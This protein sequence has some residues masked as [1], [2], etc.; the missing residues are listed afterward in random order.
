MRAAIG[1]DSDTGVVTQPYRVAGTP[2]YPSKAKQAR[3]RTLVEPTR[4]VEH[5][6]R[7]QA[8]AATFASA[9]GAA[10][11]HGG[12]RRAPDEV[13]LPDELLRDIHVSGVSLGVGP[14]ADK[15]RSGLFHRAVAELKKRHWTVDQIEALLARY[16]NG[17]A[18]KYAGRL[19]AE[20]ERSFKKVEN[21]NMA[22]SAHGAG[23]GGTPPPPAPGAPSGPTPGLAPNA[24]PQAAHVLPTIQLVAGQLPRALR[25]TEKA[26][27]S[28]GIDVFARADSLVYPVGEVVWAAKKRGTVAA[29]LRKFTVDSFFEPVAE[30]ATFQ[31]Y[32]ARRKKWVDVDPPLQLVRM[33]LARERK[34]AFPQVVGIIATTTLR[35]DGSLLAT[36]S[37]DP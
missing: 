35:P 30:S 24:G 25:E 29:K 22:Q 6:E 33:L 26:V 19:R 11:L 13:R 20:I 21:G 8:T 23:F 34:W 3:G 32:D 7:L 2:N 15:S 12:V 16:L 9:P 18:A 4:I 17:V 5:L 27:L 1:A 14:R 31:R 28:A 10:T 36:P 37:Y